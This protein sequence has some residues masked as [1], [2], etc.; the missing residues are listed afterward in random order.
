[1]NITQIAIAG[2][3]IA[4]AQLSDRKRS[5][6]YRPEYNMITGSIEA[7]ILIQQIWYWWERSDRK[8]FYKFRQPCDDAKYKDGDSWIEELGF[9][10]YQFD[11]ARAAIGAKITKGTSKSESLSN[12]LVIYWTDSNRLTWYQLNEQIF[13]TLVGLAYE[14]PEL[15]EDFDLQKRLEDFDL[16]NFIDDLDPQKRLYSETTTEN[17]TKREDFSVLPPTDNPLSES[18]LPTEPINGKRNNLPEGDLLD[19][20]LHFATQDELKRP[21]GWQRVKK[22]I[23]EVCE[24]VA[25]LW[26]G[27]RIPLLEQGDD[28]RIKNWQW[29]AKK[30]LEYH[31]GD[32]EATKATLRGFYAHYVETNSTMALAG[33][34]SLINV[35]SQFMANESKSVAS[36]P[37]VIKVGR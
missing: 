7:S 30:L 15:L 36:G 18:N 5:I 21:E 12:S 22:P 9:T 35:V 32:L 29:G 8:P 34:Q 27:G 33:P 13:F 10:P 11:K 6:P 25:E 17:T 16:Q 4:N 23:F 31:D 37:K 14:S 26:F 19:C 2:K 1:M 3:A 20:A 28:K 24:L